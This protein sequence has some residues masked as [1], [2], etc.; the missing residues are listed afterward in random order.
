[1][2]CQQDIQVRSQ[3]TGP[4][5]ISTELEPKQYVVNWMVV[6]RSVVLVHMAFNQSIKSEEKFE[7]CAKERILSRR[8]ICGLFGLPVWD[9]R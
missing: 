4:L 3:Y 9:K 2:D 5:M 1:M 6:C 8:A 7:G